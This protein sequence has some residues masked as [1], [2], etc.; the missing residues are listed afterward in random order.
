MGEDM[1]LIYGRRRVA[2][3]PNQITEIEACIVPSSVNPKLR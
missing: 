1:A 3:I 2:L